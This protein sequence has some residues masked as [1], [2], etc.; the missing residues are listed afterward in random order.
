MLVTVRKAGVGFLRVVLLGVLALVQNANGNSILINGSSLNW[1]ALTTGS[2]TGGAPSS[3]DTITL[4]GG[5]TLTVDIAN[6]V[7][8]SI[9]LGSS[10]GGQP[11]SGNL[12]FNAGSQATVSGTVTVGVSGGSSSYGTVT[13]TSG[14]TLICQNLAV[15]AMAG[16]SW[17][18]G[19]GI[20]QLTANNTLPT[21]VITNFNALI[22]SAGTTTLGTSLMVNN[23]TLNGGTLAGSCSVLVSNV[24]SWTGGTITGVVQCN[25]TG[26]IGTGV[27]KF[28]Q[29]GQLINAGTLNWKDNLT[30]GNATAPA[31]TLITNQPGATINLTAGYGTLNGG[32][33]GT[34][35]IANNGSITM[36]GSGTSSFSDIFNNF[37]IVT[38]NG[39]TLALSGGDRNGGFQRRDH[40]HE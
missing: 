26:T 30:T 38:V 2:G 8:G 39:G 35:T 25:G 16:D 29:G 13:M 18:P 7:C 28:L 27:A 34:R 1:S 20:V 32:G 5:A 33:T 21:T 4:F 12:V 36:T 3:S 6:A 14:G 24:F 23:F 31:S 37:G 9:Q 22:I 17:S 40:C 19:A 10:S 15:G 11:G